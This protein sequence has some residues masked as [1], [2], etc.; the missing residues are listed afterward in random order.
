[1]LNYRYMLCNKG[2][3]AVGQEGSLVDLEEKMLIC[4]K[5]VDKCM[6]CE[7]TIKEYEELR[8]QLY[9]TM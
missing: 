3:I 7:K 9:G 5:C 8:N 4:K 2:Y 1:M 6:S